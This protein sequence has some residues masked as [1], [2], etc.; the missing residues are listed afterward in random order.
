VSFGIA[1]YLITHSLSSNLA[2]DSSLAHTGR[3]EVCYFIPEAGR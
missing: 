1:A 2:L 3:M